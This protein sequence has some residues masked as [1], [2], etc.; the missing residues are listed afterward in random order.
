MSQ[1]KQKLTLKSFIKPIIFLFLIGFFIEYLWSSFDAIFLELLE[2]SVWLIFAICFLGLA[3]QLVEGKMV[4]TTVQVT[5]KPFRSFDGMMASCYAAFYRVVT[6]GAGTWIAEINFY[7]RKKLTISEGLGVSVFRFMLFKTAASFLAILFLILENRFFSQ[8][9]I[10]VV[11]ACIAINL[12]INAVILLAALSMPL[13]V[14]FVTL[15]DRWIKNPTWREKVDQINIQINA[16]R[17]MTNELMHKKRLLV[18]MLFWGIVKALIWF[19]IP[20]ICLKPDYPDFNFFTSLALI[21]F[22]TVISGVVPTPGGIGSFE[23]SYMVLFSPYVGKIDAASSLLLYRFATFLLPFIIG[24]SYVF[25][26]R[27]RYRKLKIQ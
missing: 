19:I 18:E 27:K 9:V 24:G 11:I 13:Q 6:F 4:K 14:L 10:W 2:T 25:F 17:S 15:C 21:S 5:N 8:R 12:I 16:L 1:V 26:T 20:Y 3:Y 7:H 22:V 23:V